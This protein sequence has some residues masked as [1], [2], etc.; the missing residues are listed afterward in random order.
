MKVILR[1][2][3]LSEAWA[4]HTALEAEDIEA[5]VNGEQS[6]GTVA[7]GLSVV[8]FDDAQLDAARAVLA[9]LEHGA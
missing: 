8:I 6:L 7:G 3:S 4:L 5:A 2:S 1:T 9:R